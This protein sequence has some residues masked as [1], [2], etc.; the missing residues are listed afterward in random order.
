[1]D[2]LQLS[3]SFEGGVAAL[4]MGVEW[5]LGNFK[6]PLTQLNWNCELITIIF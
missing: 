6:N 5:K 4:I 3:L 2:P 1:V